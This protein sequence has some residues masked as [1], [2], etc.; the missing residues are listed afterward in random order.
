M[1]GGIVAVIVNEKP[2]AVEPRIE[3]KSECNNSVVAG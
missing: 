2:D 3:A 1:E